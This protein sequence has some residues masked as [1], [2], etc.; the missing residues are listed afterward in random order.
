MGSP[1]V[2]S[3]EVISFCA[4]CVAFSLSWLCLSDEQQDPQAE[5]VTAI[6]ST[7][8]SP[9]A[10]VRRESRIVKR[11]VPKK[12]TGFPDATDESNPTS[13]SEMM[14][15]LIHDKGRKEGSKDEGEEDEEDGDDRSSQHSRTNSTAGSPAFLSADKVAARYGCVC[16]YA[17]C[18]CV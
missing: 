14:K 10:H 4:S 7:R 17:V 16:V 8:P 15:Q 13:K 12:V 2:S 11:T 6:T 5:S 3:A 1:I 9:A 18:A